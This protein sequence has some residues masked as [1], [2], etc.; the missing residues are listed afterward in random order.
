MNTKTIENYQIHV[1]GVVWEFPSVTLTELPEGAWGISRREL[2]RVYR[3]IA[4][5]VCGVGGPL[6]QDALEFLCDVTDTTFAAV[7]VLLGVDK[8]TISKWRDRGCPV[9]LLYSLHLKKFFWFKLFGTQLG[10]YSVPLESVIDESEL[11]RL[12]SEKAIE[13]DLTVRVEPCHRSQ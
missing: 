10:K 2:V 8:S 5:R 1:S 4:N 9:P 13:S 11:L 6:S 7:A 12:M 3:G